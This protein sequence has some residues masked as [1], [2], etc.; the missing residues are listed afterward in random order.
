MEDTFEDKTC[1]FGED[2]KDDMEDTINDI[3]DKS[4]A[5]DIND[6]EI[7]VT[8]KNTIQDK[9]DS[10]GEDIKDGTINDKIDISIG[11]DIKETTEDTVDSMCEVVRK[12]L[13]KKNVILCTQYP[14]PGN[15]I[16]KD[17]CFQ[18]F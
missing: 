13:T 16:I 10:F 7:D 5:E 9:S 4:I 2:N 14:L 3:I 18:T 12:F 17:I 11:E 6:E 1:T 8:I 15:N